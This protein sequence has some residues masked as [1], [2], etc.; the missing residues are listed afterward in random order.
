MAFE[1]RENVPQNLHQQ[2]G[3]NHLNKVLNYAPMVEESGKATVYLTPE[4]WHVV[5]D[6]LFH[7]EL[8]KGVLPESIDSFER[9]DDQ[10][11]IKLTTSD[12]VID[13]E[14]I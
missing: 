4:D 6:T 10:T 3:V 2:Q 14:M 8:P 12:M 1:P 7:M 5:A 9:S 13:I 11:S